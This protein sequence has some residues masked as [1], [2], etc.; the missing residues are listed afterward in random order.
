MTYIIKR[1]TAKRGEGYIVGELKHINRVLVKPDMKFK[2][3]AFA[4]WPE[5][6]T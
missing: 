6:W 4:P 3:Q 2:A 5:T 1:E